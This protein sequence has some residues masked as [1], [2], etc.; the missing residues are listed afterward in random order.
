ML[1]MSNAYSVQVKAVP[2]SSHQAVL[3]SS[4]Q[5]A[6]SGHEAMGPLLLPDQLLHLV[7]QAL[8]TALVPAP[9]PDPV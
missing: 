3:A 1:L 7:P 6:G 2:D 5:L 8:L 4:L 9:R